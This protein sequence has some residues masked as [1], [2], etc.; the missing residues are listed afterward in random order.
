M[1]ERDR[2]R[3]FA[4]KLKEEADQVFIADIDIL[5]EDR[6]TFTDVVAIKGTVSGGVSL[7]FTRPNEMVITCSGIESFLNLSV[8]TALGSELGK[9]SYLVYAKSGVLMRMTELGPSV[10]APSGYEELEWIQ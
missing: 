3:D 2:M 5:Y 9:Q 4:A 1:H 7:S 6:L 10:E 8:P